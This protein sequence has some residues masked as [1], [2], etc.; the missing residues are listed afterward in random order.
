MWFTESCIRTFIALLIIALSWKWP[1]FSSIRGW[2]NKLWFIHATEY[3]SAVKRKEPLTNTIIHINFK[4]IV[5]SERSFIQNGTC[6]AISFRWSSRTD[7][8]IS[9][10]KTEKKFFKELANFLKWPVL[11]SIPSALY[12]NSSSFISL[13]TLGTVRLL[14]F[15]YSNVYIVMPHCG[16]NFHF[17]NDQWYWTYVFFLNI[18]CAYLPFIYL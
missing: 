5:M 4:G 7:K 1:R 9:S 18:F 16:F 2:I 11:L 17:H 10:G 3:C 6:G 8:I 13:L 14:N 12:E 15:S